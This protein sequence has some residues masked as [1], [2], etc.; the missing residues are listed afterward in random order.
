MMLDKEKTIARAITHR[1]RHESSMTFQT[2][3]Q[4]DRQ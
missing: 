1:F 4:L 2:E 3:D